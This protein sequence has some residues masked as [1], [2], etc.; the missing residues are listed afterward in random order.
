MVFISVVVSERLLVA[1]SYISAPMLEGSVSM[2]QWS[3]I[4]VFVWISLVHVVYFTR[5][6]FCVLLG[7]V[8]VLCL[9]TVFSE[10][11]LSNQARWIYSSAQKSLAYGC[12]RGDKSFHSKIL[13]SWPQQLRV[14][15]VCLVF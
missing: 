7:C 11:E 12:V 9:W 8:C 10:K 6:L 4:S 14:L 15:T 1:M 3:G 2:L 13:N 5:G